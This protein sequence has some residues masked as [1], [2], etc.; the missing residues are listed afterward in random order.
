MRSLAIVVCLP[1]VAC[2]SDR[3]VPENA[4]GDRLNRDIVSPVRESREDCEAL[5]DQ[6]RAQDDR[7][8]LD[9][10]DRIALRRAG[11][12]GIVGGVSIRIGG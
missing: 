7:G 9:A 8:R 2:V 3:T 6:L 10:Q 1:L 12:E 11:C 4:D 5:R